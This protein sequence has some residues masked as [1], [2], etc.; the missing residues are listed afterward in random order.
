MNR[1]TKYSVICA[2]ALFSA[3]LAALLAAL[4]TACGS[5]PSEVSSPDGRIKIALTTESDGVARYEVTV[6]GRLLIKP[7]QLGLEARGKDFTRFVRGN[8]R[9]ASH[10]EIWHS[11]WG[12]NKEHLN[13]YN[14]LAVQLHDAR[15]ENG[16]VTVRMRAFDDGV[17]FRYEL[18]ESDSL[19][20]TDELTEFRFAEEG[21]S[22]SIAGNFETYELPYRELPFS[23]VEDANTPFT[24]RTDSGIY[25]SVHEA[26]LYDYPEMVLRRRDDGDGFRSRLAPLPDGTKARIAG[27]F[28]TPWRTIQIGGKAVDLINSSLI[29]NLNEPSKIDD[30]SWIRPQKYVGVWWG[31]HLGTQTWVMG[32]RHGATTDNALRHIDF[33]AENNV[34][35]VLFEGWNR[36]WEN[37]GGDQHFDYVEPY[38][39]FD[40]E[41][42]AAYAR[43]KGVALWMHNETGGNIPEYEAEMERAMARYAELGVHTLKTGYAGGFKGGYLHHSQYGVQHY[44]RVVEL[45]AKYRIMIDAHEP[46]K[47][48]GIRRTWPNMMTREGARGMEWNAWSEGNSSEYLCTLPF[49][50]LLGGPMDYTPGVFDIDYSAAKADKGRLQWNGDNSD[51][52]I[53]TTLARQIA[54]W[55]I[56][57][58]PLQMACDLIENYEGHPAFAFF[59]DY[60]ADCDMSQALQ[61]EIGDYIVVMRRAGERFFIGA[62]TDSEARTICLPLDFLEAGRRYT[63]T[64]YADDTSSTDPEAYT[65][66]RSE[67][68][69]DDTLLLELL[70]DG[71]AAATFIPAE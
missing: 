43:E 36:G 49:V 32:P 70:P 13:R 7:S 21:L 14:E 10:D 57:Y 59:S 51:C 66:T 26:A 55:V 42:I 67:V 34:D 3:L 58:S 40:L 2:A 9:R 53:K 31:M 45:A 24:F 12:E 1:L 44:Q 37:W 15:G 48:T 4:L 35:G 50:R 25:G 8:S 29:L 16:G 39:D 18:N 71:G 61:G 17:A 52:C 41:H 60:D 23:A 47:A 27:R 5:G 46:I 65:I 69:A 64:V 6:D 56:I 63:A 20:V 62:G 22:W 54:N 11:P 38:D 19:V 30:T 68:T 28:V 33:A